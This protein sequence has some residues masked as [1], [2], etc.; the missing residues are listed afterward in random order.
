LREEVAVE[1]AEA[2]IS[3]MNYSL[4]TAGLDVSTG[5]IDVDILMTGRS[6]S[7]WEKI[8]I[9]LKEIETL[10]AETGR[11]LLSEL[12]KRCE[13]KKIESDE[14]YKL[15][16]QMREQ[17]IIMLPDEETVRRIRR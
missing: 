7:K 6:R 17:G 11:A 10:E 15:I 8:R 4:R 12:R 2:A 3:L 9:I 16:E 14:F 1:D 5:K 13:E